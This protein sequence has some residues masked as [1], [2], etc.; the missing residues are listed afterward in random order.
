[1]VVDDAIA[2]LGKAP[3]LYVNDRVIGADASYALPTQTV[4]DNALMALFTDNVFRAVPEDINKS[5]FADFGF[6]LH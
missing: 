4:T 1:M 3:K 5:C 6:K 2:A